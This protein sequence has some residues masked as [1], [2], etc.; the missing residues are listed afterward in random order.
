MANVFSF[1]SPVIPSLLGPA[2]ARRGKNDPCVKPSQL[3]PV[4]PPL[5]QLLINSYFL[6][7]YSG[8]RVEEETSAAPSA[9]AEDIIESPTDGDFVLPAA[10]GATSQHEE[11]L[12][13]LPHSDTPEAV[14]TAAV[15][16][17]VDVATEAA[18][19]ETSSQPTTNAFEV[20]KKASRE[21]AGSKAPLSAPPG[22]PR[23]KAKKLTK[24]AP[25]NDKLDQSSMLGDK[26]DIY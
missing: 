14:G 26:A 25:K 23:Q 20:M 16:E 11:F 6:H 7:S 1:P 24:K 4:P 13:D 18:V 3:V 21:A 2:P 8:Y 19:S 5:W 9:A 22:R 12:T 10:S 15:V 17:A